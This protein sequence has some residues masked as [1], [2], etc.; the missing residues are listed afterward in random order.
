MDSNNQLQQ[1]IF[2]LLDKGI[3]TYRQFAQQ[4]IHSFGYNLTIDQWLVL[5][6]LTENPGL[7]QAEIAGLVFK[8]NASLTRI[9][10][11][12]VGKGYIDRTLSKVDRRKFDLRITE[13]GSQLLGDVA[14]VVKE[15]R[16]QALQDIT[17]DEIQL[18]SK[19]LQKLITNCIIYPI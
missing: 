11:L 12:L 6:A 15:N 5:S 4:R 13:L 9:I 7:S 3:R 1:N 8:D 18:L 19:I 17:E 16:K 14:K 10:D 2:Y